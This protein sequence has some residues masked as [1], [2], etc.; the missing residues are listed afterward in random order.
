MLWHV[1]CREAVELLLEGL[2]RHHPPIMPTLLGFVRPVMVYCG[3]CMRRGMLYY[4]MVTLYITAAYSASSVRMGLQPQS[5]VL[6][7]VGS[8]VVLTE[9][10][11]L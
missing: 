11:G 8:Q 1:P 4:E 9:E 2:T 6:G 7:V 3:A 10:W 5:A